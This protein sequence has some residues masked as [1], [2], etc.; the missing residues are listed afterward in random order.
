M[1]AMN[2]LLPVADLYRLPLHPTY[3]L[4]IFISLFT[5]RPKCDMN[6]AA[7]YPTSGRNSSRKAILWKQESLVLKR[8]GS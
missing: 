1:R 8:S 5:N 2:C 4:K 3:P 7:L 6:I